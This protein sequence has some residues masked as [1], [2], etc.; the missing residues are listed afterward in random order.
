MKKLSEAHMLKQVSL[1]YTIWKAR[2]FNFRVPAVAY[3]LLTSQCNMKCRYCFLECN[4]DQQEFTLKEWLAMVNVLT[5]RGCKQIC[6]MGGEPLLFPGIEQLIDQIRGRKCICDITTNGLLVEQNLKLLKKCDIVMLSLDGMKKS[7]EANRQNWQ[8]VFDALVLLKKNKIPTR[9]N[10]VMTKQTATPVNINWLLERGVPVTFALAAGFPLSQ[11]S[12]EKEILLDDED[13]RKLYLLLKMKKQ[14]GAPVL[15]SYESLDYMIHYPHDFKSIR[16]E[17]DYF[18]KKCPFGQQMFYI[19]S[20][21]D[22][23][24]C[25]ALWHEVSL[26]EPKNIFKEGWEVCWEHVG[27]LSC[28]Y[29]FCVGIPEW[30]RLTSARGIMDG[31]RLVSKLKRG[32]R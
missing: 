23:Y 18:K 13:V 10:A 32:G 6:L 26:Y 4:R 28:K 20:N 17:G 3:L 21:G 9:I 12:L 5:D 14:Q 30:D 1:F 27:D 25:A 11:K 15:F 2:K 16:L 22:F 8:R 29:C 31:I 24:P 19:D 7:H